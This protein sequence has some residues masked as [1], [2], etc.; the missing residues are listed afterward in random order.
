V[1]NQYR[2]L[3]ESLLRAGRDD[4]GLEA[5]RHMI[6]YGRTSYDLQLGF[7]TETVAYDVSTLCEHA[8]AIGRS[9]VADE[10]LTL[11]LELDQEVRQRRQE[12]SL[13]GVR[14]AQV[15]LACYYLSVG[16]ESWARRIADDMAGEAPDRLASIRE[17]LESVESKDFW[18][19]IDRG[20]N[21]EYMPPHQK[22]EMGR[23]FG[24]LPV[25]GDST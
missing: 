12:A 24:W 16:A 8:H 17:Q 19:I 6:Y 14:K 9:A 7:V 20:R 5:V 1:L 11:F 18:E 25:P 21:F 3:A 4:E 23:F 15:K 10:M 2:L 13:Q 22:R